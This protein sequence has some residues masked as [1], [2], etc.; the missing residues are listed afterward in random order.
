MD[1]KK[2]TINIDVLNS[3]D[4]SAIIKAY[5][6]RLVEDM[7]EDNISCIFSTENSVQKIK[8]STNLHK[9]S[10]TYKKHAKTYK[11]N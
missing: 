8:N 4:N 11:N 5:H 6:D 10:K 3:R 2:T 7:T 1:E 9:Q